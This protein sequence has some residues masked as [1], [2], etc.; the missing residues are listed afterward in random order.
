[1]PEPRYLLC[2]FPSG[3]GSCSSAAVAVCQSVFPVSSGYRALCRKAVVRC[4]SRATRAGFSS[5]VSATSYP[6]MP[7]SE[8]SA[9]KR[10]SRVLLP[11]L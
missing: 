4:W 9:P 11:G 7:P 10:V 3:S 1:M 2:N 8:C 5:V 6:G